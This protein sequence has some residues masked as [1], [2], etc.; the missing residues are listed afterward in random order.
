MMACL[1]DTASCRASG[2]SFWAPLGYPVADLVFIGLEYC[3]LRRGGCNQLPSWIEFGKWARYDTLL[4][5]PAS[6]SVKVLG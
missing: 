3:V 2:I 6:F 4:V 1:L 5:L